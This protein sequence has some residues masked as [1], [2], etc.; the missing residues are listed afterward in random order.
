MKVLNTNYFEIVRTFERFETK[1]MKSVFLFL[2]CLL[3]IV[4]ACE[5]D[6]ICTGGGTPKLTV[7]FRNQLNTSNMPDTLSIYRS[8]N[9]GFENPDTIYQ[10]SFTDSIKL[11]LG[12]MNSDKVYFQIRRRSNPDMD[13]LTVAYNPKSTFVSKA[14]GFKIIYENLA[15]Q[16][17]QQHINYLIPAETNELKDETITNLIV[18]LGN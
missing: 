5:E 11:P 17:T 18:V 3:F 10:K 8:D 9:I 1:R 13:L 2:I 6:D 4:T 15:Y 7:V 14:C 12:G 16:T